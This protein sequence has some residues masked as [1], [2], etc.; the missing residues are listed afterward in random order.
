MDHDAFI[1]TYRDINDR[2]CLYEKGILSSQCACC[3]AK[4]LYIA[5]R[6]AVHCGSDEGQQ[7]CEELLKLLRQHS[8][9]TLKS[10]DESG[11]LPHAK[12]MRIQIGGL[13]GLHVALHGNQ[14]IPASI[15]DIYGL[16]N[17]VIEQFQ[18]LDKLPF[19]DIIKEIA[20]YQGR[21][22]RSRD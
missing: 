21:K 7:H 18:S 17:D 15:E 19:Q 2:A 16:I 10:A 20:A 13:R 5:E 14:Q 1:R 9:F 12:A 11:V 3:Q 6:E 4:R 22:R 8:R